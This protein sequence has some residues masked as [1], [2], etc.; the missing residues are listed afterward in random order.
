MRIVLRSFWAVSIQGVSDTRGLLVSPTS[1][2]LFIRDNLNFFFSWRHLPVGRRD[3]VIDVG[4][5]SDPNMRADI[6]CDFY[7]ETDEERSAKLG[8]WIDRRPFVLCDIQKLPFRDKVIDY[9]L[10][11]HLLEHVEN[12]RQAVREL[13]RVGKKG[14]VETPSKLFECL[15]GWP[16]HQWMISQREDGRILFERKDPGAHGLLPD[17]VKKSREFEAL[18]SRF[19]SHF[20]VKFEWEDSCDVEVKGQEKASPP[21]ETMD[22]E[23]FVRRLKA[24]LIL[25]RKVKIF[26][27]QLIRR[28]IS[29]HFRADISEILCCPICKG[30]LLK[31]RGWLICETC[32]RQ[33]PVIDNVFFLSERTRIPLNRRAS[34]QSTQRD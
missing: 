34:G 1:L 33:F 7:P 4:S 25:R 10:C 21:Q 6:L 17:S 30:G 22:P 32:V 5:G 29:C 20:L 15:Y 16:F 2:Y 13:T 3:L 12:P 8:I 24:Q 14:R 18:V 31:G 23:D 9:V 19:H 27:I 11:T 26:L 28:L